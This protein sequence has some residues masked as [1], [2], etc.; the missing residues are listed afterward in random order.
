MFL[1]Y[2]CVKHPLLLEVVRHGVLRQ[3]W[4]LE[5]DFS[6]NPFA[7][8]MRSVRRM[9][10]SSAASKLWAEVRALDLIELIDLAPGGVADSSGDIDLEFQN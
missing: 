1:F 6:A 4:R 9:I 2:V 7:L 3:K 8:D 5:P 10:A